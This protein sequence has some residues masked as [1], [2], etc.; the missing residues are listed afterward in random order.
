[1]DASLPREPAP[2]LFDPH[3]GLSTKR[4]HPAFTGLSA[5]FTAALETACGTPAAQFGARIRAVLDEAQALADC[6]PE[7]V[8]AGK[9]EGYSRHLLACDPAG[10][11]AAA[12]IVWR[13]GQ[14]TPAHGHQTWC[15]FRIVKGVLSEERFTWDALS[16]RASRVEQR[17]C[18][19]G[20]SS[21]VPAGFGGIHRIANHSAL[22]AVSFHVYGV[23]ADDIATR[24]NRLVE[25]AEPMDMV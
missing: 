5:R 1:M 20:E 23:H 10:R 12:A 25:T 18:E 17:Q 22:N 21:F 9:A 4:A 3:T 13:P 14:C 7:E 6:L 19:A 11:F 16:G 24:V 2:A 8:L 15:G